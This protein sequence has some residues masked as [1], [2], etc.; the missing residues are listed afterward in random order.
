MF[1]GKDVPACGFSL[2]LE[3]ILVVMEERKM[4]PADFESL[5]AVLAPVEEGD[6]LAALQL[7]NALRAQGLRIDLMPKGTAPGKLRKHADDQA[8]SAAIWIEPGQRDRA[9]LWSKRDG[10]TH[11]DLTVTALVAAL[12]S[13]SGSESE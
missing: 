2:G 9:S 7:S 11:K 3:R 8:I 5:H 12:R 1:L 10:Q 6:L 13:G 4:Y